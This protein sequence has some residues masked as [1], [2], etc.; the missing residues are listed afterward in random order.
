MYNDAQPS[1]SN[2]IIRHVRS[3]IGDRN[4]FPTSNWLADD[5]ITL[6]GVHDGIID[7]CSFAHAETRR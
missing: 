3:R 6:G 1:V 7:H 4:L 5:G 2:I